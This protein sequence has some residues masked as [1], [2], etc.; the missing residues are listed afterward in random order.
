MARSSYLLCLLFAVLISGGCSLMPR[1]LNLTP[2][3]FHRLDGN[4]EL[5]EWDAA[6]PILHYERTADGGDDFRVRPFYRRVTEPSPALPE[7]EAVE[8]Q[9]LVPLGRVKSYPDETSARLFPLWSWRS[10]VNDD[11]ERDV[12]WYLLFPF[13][14]GGYSA[15]DRENYFAVFPFYADIPEFLTYDR[16]RTVL[17]P[18]WV[19]MDKSG[20][21]YDSVLWP[22]IGWSNC[23]EGRHRWLR[24]LPFYGHNVEEGV[25]D[26]RFL[27]WPFFAWST[28]NEDGRSG[29]V[30]SYWFWPL[31]GWRSGADTTGWMAL[32]PFFQ[33]TS[34]RDHF[35]VL[36][37]FWPLWRYYWNR[38]EDNVTQWWFWPFVSHVESDDQRA[39]TFLWP[40]MWFRE[41][42][43]PEGTNS[44]QWVLP[45]FW[46]IVKD[47]RDGPREEHVKLWPIAHSTVE[48]DA[49]GTVLRSNWSALSPFPLRN[50]SA[51][52]I[53][54]AYGWLWQLA[55]GVQR[56]PDDRAVDVV[57]RLYTHRSRSDGTTASVPLLFNYE[58]DERG[59][60][61][62]RLFQFL[63][64]P[65]GSASQ[66]DDGGT[67]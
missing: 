9:F 65:L 14:W 63:P 15:D 64:I 51:T 5:L 22:F 1:E 31:V 3:W 30:D 36:T 50:S 42:D 16:W 60:R 58:Q 19:S 24:I 55:R 67:E 21:H 56:A 39:W 2:L 37:L 66:D 57:G 23:A 32:W 10:R 46:R 17:F 12:D 49:D 62:L 34:K 11:G 61:T 7:D 20:H 13:V 35:F 59:E 40:L 38:A 8:H 28:E 27:L 18:L 43:D 52:G 41:Y 26:R 29:P 45:F 47:R 54:E 6:W 33:S 4:G 25:F 44:Q 48:T 53:E